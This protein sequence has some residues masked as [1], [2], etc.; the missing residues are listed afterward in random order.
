MVALSGGVDSSAATAKLLQAGYDCFAAYMITGEQGVAEQGEAQKV[1]DKL[2]VKL[3][4]LDLREEFK[5]I[6]EYFASEYQKGRTPNPCVMC[7]KEIKFGKLWEFAQSQESDFIATG[8]YI[9]NIEQDGEFGI[10]QATN[11]K[12][13]QSYVLALI[14]PKVIPHI[15]FPLG[16]QDKDTTRKMAENFN[17]G[18][19]RKGESQEIC[20]IPDD[21]YIAEIEKRCPQLVRQGDIIDS[22]GKIL[23]GHEGIHRFTIG[24]RRGLKV[25]MGVP[26]YVTKLDA[27]ANTVTLGPKQEVMHR[28]L[29]TSK[30]NQLIDWP[31]ETFA[32]MVKIRYNSPARPANVTPLTDGTAEISFDEPISAITPGQLAAVYIKQP[33]GLRLIGGG[34]IDSVDN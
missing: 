7:N 27:A 34:W 3:H 26:Y 1:A 4:I 10:Y 5:V 9:R 19:E 23:G 11:F 28:T 17:L 30:V 2:N 24:Q 29:R 14:N 31:E 12:K 22:S 16:E 8:H 6:G 21:D 18:L 25:A 13:D 20:F 32:A 33:A 15:I